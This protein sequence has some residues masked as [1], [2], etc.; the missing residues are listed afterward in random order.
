MHWVKFTNKIT[1]M[2]QQDKKILINLGNRIRDLR[3]AK[4][5][6]LNSFAFNKGITSATLS[7]IENGLVDVKFITLVKLSNA[8][9]TPL[10]ELLK[11]LDLKYNLD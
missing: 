4:N 3:V 11:G 6:S 8:L 1:R 9:E 7:R 2:Q 10:E 5:K